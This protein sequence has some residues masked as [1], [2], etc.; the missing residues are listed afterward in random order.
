MKRFHVVVPW[1]K[2]LHLLPATRLARMSRKFHSNIFLRCGE[3]MADLRSV[4]SVLT[5]CAAMGAT[6][7]V[8]VVGDDE[9]DA[10]AAV[11]AIFASSD[12]EVVPTSTRSLT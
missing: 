11:E 4:L 1:Q 2:G 10:V 7:D 5:L 6:I 12:E 3:K 9:P 8:R